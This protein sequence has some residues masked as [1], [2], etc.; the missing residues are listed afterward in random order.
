[1]I[2]KLSD[3][4][5]FN[6]YLQLY[7]VCLHLFTYIYNCTPNYI[8]G[9]VSSLVPSAVVVCRSGRAR[10]VGGVLGGAR[11]WCGSSRAGAG[12][13]WCPRWCPRRWWC[14]VQGGRGVWVVSWVCSVAVVCHSGR[15]RGVGGVLGG[16]LGGGGVDHPGRARGVVGVLGGALGGGGVDHPGRARGVVGVLGGARWHICSRPPKRVHARL[17]SAAALSPVNRNCKES[18]LDAI[19]L[20]INYLG[21]PLGMAF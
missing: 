1:M 14:V 16:A 11:W 6:I 4:F 15:A 18:L 9:L 3:A 10:G 21:V 2:K 12:C 5:T 20:I 19:A 13:G 17:L 8:Y 7:I